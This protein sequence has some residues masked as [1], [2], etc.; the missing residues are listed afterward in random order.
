MLKVQK[1]C[2]AGDT[3]SVYSVTAC[4]GA[5]RTPLPYPRGALSLCSITQQ[6]DF[7]LGRAG[8]S[9]DALADQVGCFD[10]RFLKD[11]AT[12]QRFAD[13]FHFG[14]VVVV[15]GDEVVTALDFC[16]DFVVKDKA[17]SGV[18]AVFDAFTACTELYGESA[19][20]FAGDRAD[21]TV[22]W[23]GENRDTARLGEAA[24]IFDATGISTL[25]RDD[26]LEL[27]KGCTTGDQFVNALVGG[28]DIFVAACHRDHLGGEVEREFAEIVANAAT[29][30]FAG[31]DDFEAVADVCAEGLAHIG[32]QGDHLFVHV[33]SDGYELLCE[34]AG[35]VDIFH[36][37]AVAEFDVE[38]EAVDIFR[39]FFAHDARRD[40]G[41]GFDGG[42][43]IAQCV[44]FAVGGNEVAGLTGHDEAAGL[45]DLLKAFGGEVGGEA[46]DG[47]EFIEGSA[48][49]SESAST[50]HRDVVSG[51]C[52]DGC[53][54]QGGFVTDAARG[55]FIDFVTLHM[56]EVEDIAR[57][58]H[59]ACPRHQFV[60]GQTAKKDRHRHR[61]GLIIGDGFVGVA[62]NKGAD[63]FGG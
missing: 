24:V 34:F 15:H 43:D 33:E 44:E 8:F 28:I 60:I 61:R 58:E 38:D 29:Q 6:A 54:D 18:D 37:S 47:F 17:N 11:K 30:D 26:L 59:C 49:V 9:D 2:C 1:L 39:E 12:D 51:G 14:F 32:E 35:F 31:F 3:T 5:L 41:D 21:V 22:A 7:V 4:R 20:F 10:G 42:G 27:A 25:C 16:A 36:K 13:G 40:Q 63:L 55:M 48:R 50:D 57:F 56:G 53:E 52:D 46:G 45:K 23:A 62:L 19:D